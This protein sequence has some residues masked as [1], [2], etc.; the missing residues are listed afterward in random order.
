MHPVLPLTR[1]P[2]GARLSP[3]VLPPRRPYQEPFLQNAHFRYSWLSTADLHHIG[4]IDRSEE[5]RVGYEMR[6]GSLR[7]IDVHWD[8]PPWHPDGEGDHTVPA[9][10][11]FCRDH[12]DRGA[13]SYGAFDGEK[14][15]GIGVLLP[16]LREGMAQLSFLHVSRPHRH[17]GIAAGLV[18]ELFRVAGEHGAAAVYVSS[19]PT[20]SAVG[21]YLRQGFLVADEPD[22]ELLA[23]E[24]E[25]IHMV[26]KL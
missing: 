24:P 16:E 10:I 7:R 5:V 4:D 19:A 14:L 1:A 6:D 11:A 22:P 9:K 8:V 25:D 18:A 17:V 26:K 15:A 12:M 20:E 13:V 3:I 21:F 2:A 23:L